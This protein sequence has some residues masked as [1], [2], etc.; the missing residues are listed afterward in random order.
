MDHRT[1]NLERPEFRTRVDTPEDYKAI[2]Y[3]NF[4]ERI[5][6]DVH[7]VNSC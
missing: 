7:V 3:Y 1:G 2:S 5:T 6:A 4:G